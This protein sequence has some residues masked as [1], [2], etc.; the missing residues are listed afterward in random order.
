MPKYKEA[1][2]KAVVQTDA[3]KIS[4]NLTPEKKKAN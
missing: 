2:G 1:A 3:I 4:V